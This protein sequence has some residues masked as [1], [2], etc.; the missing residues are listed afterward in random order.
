MTYDGDSELANLRR[1]NGKDKAWKNEFFGIGY[2]RWGCGG[3]MTA[4]EY[5]R[6]YRHF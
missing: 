1:K 4:D 2:E 5:A 6:R 3:N